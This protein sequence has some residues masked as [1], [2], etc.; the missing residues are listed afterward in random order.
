MS[1]KPFKDILEND[2]Y[3]SR[4]E[5]GIIAK[6]GLANFEMKHDQ[7]ITEAINEEGIDFL[8]KRE[9]ELFDY[10]SQFEKMTT[11]TM[12]MSRNI[13]CNVDNKKL[14]KNE[15]YVIIKV[16]DIV[17]KIVDLQ[18]ISMNFQLMRFEVNQVLN[19]DASN[20]IAEI[21]K[22]GKLNTKTDRFVWNYRK[23]LYYPDDNWSLIFNDFYYPKKTFNE[24]LNV[25][26]ELTSNIK[27]DSYL[28]T[29]IFT[30]KL[31]TEDKYFM[32]FSRDLVRVFK[33]FNFSINHNGRTQDYRDRE[34]N[35]HN[36]NQST[37]LLHDNN[38]VLHGTLSTQVERKNS[39]STASDFPEEVGVS[40]QIN[41]LTGY[42]N[43]HYFSMRS[44]ALQDK[45]HQPLQ[46]SCK[47]QYVQTCEKKN[48]CKTINKKEVCSDENVCINKKIPMPE[49]CNKAY[50]MVLNNNH[51]YTKEN[52]YEFQLNYDKFLNKH[53]GLLLHQ[54]TLKAFFKRWSKMW[55]TL[56]VGG[57]VEC[58]V[59]DKYTYWEIKFMANNN[60]DDTFSYRLNRKCLNM[61][62]AEYGYSQ[63]G[64]FNDYYR[65]GDKRYVCFNQFGSFVIGCAKTNRRVR[66]LDA[67]LQSN[68][69]F[70]KSNMPLQSV[71]NYE[72]WQPFYGYKVEDSTSVVNHYLQLSML[73]P[74][75][76]VR[77]DLKVLQ[78]KGAHLTSKISFI[79]RCP[80]LSYRITPK[81][82]ENINCQKLMERC[83]N[84][85][86]TSNNYCMNG[87]Y[88]TWNVTGLIYESVECKDPLYDYKQVDN[89]NNIGYGVIKPYLCL[90]MNNK[91]CKNIGGIYNSSL[92]AFMS[93]NSTK[94]ET[95]N[96]NF[97]VLDNFPESKGLKKQNMEISQMYHDLYNTYRKDLVEI[98]KTRDAAYV[99]KEK[100]YE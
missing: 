83:K 35:P 92:V 53:E 8:Y 74:K 22:S 44:K 4:N 50:L 25:F 1:S 66:P 5:V 81:N 60:I 63:T 21:V 18:D 61:N 32:I 52:I 27:K 54:T 28:K 90:D 64:A 3:Y 11:K 30:R 24:Q 13:L 9:I 91:E 68:F 87:D 2:I 76:K 34:F 62:K 36:D 49:I 55:M 94:S 46:E 20:E 96:P 72:E 85:V 70:D 95:V 67:K 86:K 15:A 29:E 98:K 56:F 45:F 58:R 73:P 93:T 84:P 16:D 38:L 40:L 7:T 43:N 10:L 14:Y 48:I 51:H 6:D 65:K 88:M 23:K 31:D 17:Q 12:N 41:Q 82:G 26:S 99:I 89:T 33:F 69:K 19:P 59:D 42:V 80:N 97:V 47:D 78:K 37:D 79:C 57:K 71:S 77:K 39:E 75:I 100:E